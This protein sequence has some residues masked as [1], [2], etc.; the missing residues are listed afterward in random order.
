LGKQLKQGEVITIS[1]KYS[2]TT[3]G[4]ALSWLTPEQTAGKKMPYVYSQNEPS[5]GRS[6]IPCQDTPA[7]KAPYNAQI[8]AP[9]GILVRMSANST[10]KT[11]YQ[12]K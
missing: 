8:T 2:S 10:I 5:Y 6:W 7:V 9:E 11:F 12:G 1:I 4:S 3:Q